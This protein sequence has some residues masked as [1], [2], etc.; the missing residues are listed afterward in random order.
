VYR[1]KAWLNGWAFGAFYYVSI[2][3]WA[4]SGGYLYVKTLRVGAQDS[5]RFF[6]GWTMTFGGFMLSYGRMV[7]Y[8]R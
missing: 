6:Y 8:D 2:S 1:E 3:F 7:G 4:A 5:M